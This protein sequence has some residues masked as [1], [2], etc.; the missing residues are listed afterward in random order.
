ME[1]LITD[2]LDKYSDNLMSVPVELEEKIKRWVEASAYYYLDE[3]VMSDSEFDDLTE[4]IKEQIPNYPFIGSIVNS[5]IQTTEGLVDVDEVTSQMISLNKIKYNGM[6]TIQ[7]I[8]KFLNP[9]RNQQINSLLFFGLKYD[10]CAIKVSQ[11]SNGDKLII[12]RGG[13]DVTSLLINHKDICNITRPITH[14]E[15]V[16]KKSIFLEKYADEYENPRNAVMGILKQNPNDLDFIE[17]TDG[18]SPLNILQGP[19]Q[20][21][22]M[23][24]NTINLESH[25]FEMKEKLQYQIDGIVIGYAVKTQEIKDNYPMNLVAIKFKSPT[26][27]T[28]VIGFLWTQKKS[29]NLTPVILV[30]PVKLDGSTIAKV[31]GYNYLNVKNSHIGIGSIVEITKSGDIIPVVQ[32]VITRSNEITMPEIDYI[33]SGKHLIAVNNEDSI[34]YKFIL[35]LKLLQLD[36]IGPVIAEKIGSMVDY[37]IIQLFNTENK[38]KIIGILG[39]GA[40]WN[41]FNIFYQT[42]NIGLDLL[43]EILQF[44]RCGKTLSKKFANII[45]KE[46]NDVSGIDKNLLNNV[47]RG[48][49]FTKI[50]KSMK[51]LHS[52]GIKVTRP[53]KINDE[54][55]SFEMTGSPSNITKQ[56]FVSKLKKQYPN[57][58]HTTLTKD[59]KYLICDSLTSSS[60]KL[61]KARKYNTKIV[62]YDDA[63]KG[64]L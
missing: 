47:C 41:N 52:F 60:G 62:T 56:E 11:K 63:L 10:G 55:I 17:C 51:L 61:N 42:K 23:Y 1:K 31:A 58:V 3:P 22:K 26:A 6:M 35:G 57:S 8:M 24:N 64:N 43:I 59:T 25:Y 29:G 2:F 39:P 13:Q 38:P 33:I 5:K 18:V 37:D 16:V 34:I 20:I 15:L 12:T 19:N 14:G 44:D 36:G 9:N 54:T 45:L 50:N 46:S 4:E 21:W 27:R 49:G 7:E 48:E 28:K 40:V 53:I 30:E 32:K